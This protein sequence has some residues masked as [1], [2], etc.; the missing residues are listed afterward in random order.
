M[1]FNILKIVSFVRAVQYS[2]FSK[3]ALSLGISTPAVSKQIKD[4][5]GFLQ[6]RLLI[7]STRTLALTE[8]GQKAFDHFEQMIRG[9]N[10]LSNELSHYNKNPYSCKLHKDKFKNIYKDYP[11]ENDSFIPFSKK[12]KFETRASLEN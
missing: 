1:L 12:S 3:A 5:E 4:L 10:D 2:S 7:R 8:A 6:V 11:C 9:L